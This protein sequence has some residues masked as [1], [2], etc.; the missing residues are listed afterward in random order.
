MGSQ[1]SG[2]EVSLELVERAER[3]LLDRSQGAV[4][5]L[6]SLDPTT[7]ARIKHGHHPQQR[8]REALMRCCGCGGRVAA[9]KPCELCACRRQKRAA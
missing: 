1:V 9:D 7:I 3:L 4:A 6:L 2:R 8:A 5:R